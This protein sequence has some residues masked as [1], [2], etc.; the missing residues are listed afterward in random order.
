VTEKFATTKMTSKGQVVI[1]EAIRKRLRLKAGSRF[2]V[3][4]RKDVVILK[5]ITAPSMKEFD[6]LV[7]EARASAGRAGM[8]RS[9]VR[10]VVRQARGRD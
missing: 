7:A 9:D 5:E 6:G 3:I 4:G 10:R 2:V 8:K 1:P